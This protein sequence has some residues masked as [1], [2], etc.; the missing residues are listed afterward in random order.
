MKNVFVEN[1]CNPLTK[2]QRDDL[3]AALKFT[4][5]PGVT[6]HRYDRVNDELHVVFFFKYGFSD[7]YMIRKV[8]HFIEVV[9]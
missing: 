9:E 1:V 6:I 5:N 3:L 8:A 7:I 4:I 2:N